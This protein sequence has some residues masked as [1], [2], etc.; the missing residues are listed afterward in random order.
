MVQQQIAVKASAKP[1]REQW[2]DTVKGVAITLVVFGHSIKIL[3]QY[4][5]ET[6]GVWQQLNIVIGEWRMPVFML[7]AGFFVTRSITKYGNRFWRMR[8]IN[9]LWLFLLWSAVYWVA[10][11]VIGLVNRHSTAGAGFAEI[12]L[13]TVTFHSY[14]WFLLAL[15]LYYAAQGLLG[16]TPKKWAVV[17]AAVLFLIFVPGLVDEVTWG[18]NELFTNWLF[19][20][21]GAW[22]SQN[23]RDW[24]AKVPTWQGVLWCVA[25]VASLGAWILTRDIPVI[26][27]FGAALPPLC[28]I[29]AGLF[30]LSRLDGKPGITWAR[31]VGPK[32]LAVYVVH[33][34][35]MQLI[36]ALGTWVAPDPSSSALSTAVYW[37]GPPVFTVIALLLC[38]VIQRATAQVPFL[39]GLPEPQSA[40][41]HRA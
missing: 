5:W 8:P 12:V 3:R 41:A 33:P 22:W 32:S 27:N 35:L 13:S 7:V 9:M 24:V 38:L 21:V 30:L 11:P 6:H 14:L 40:G 34:I 31:S 39:W 36:A 17:L 2:M 10:Y 20:L 37:V 18:T 19:F 28:A 1:M 29:P 4:D 16:V 25:F 15:A 23:I 26:E